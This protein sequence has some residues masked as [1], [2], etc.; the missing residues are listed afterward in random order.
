MR[1]IPE[2]IDR[3]KLRSTLTY[4]L[5]P[6]LAIGIE[7]N[8]LSD[9]TKVGPLL[10]WVA[11]E[12][13]DK[14]PALI[15]GTSSDRIGTPRG[16]AYFGTLSKRFKVNEKLSFSP[17]AGFSYG[18]FRDKWYTI[19]GLRTNFNDRL[20]SVL[21]YDGVNVHP[22]VEYRHG[23]HVFSAIWA[24]TQSPGVAYSVTF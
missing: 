22:T 1:W 4:R 17:Y 2:E 15:F 20:S 12:E 3:A 16:Q 9:N 11:M 5:V 23:R 21:I 13:G 6:R 19:G 24:S 8:P 10:N 7:Y 18:T 14:R